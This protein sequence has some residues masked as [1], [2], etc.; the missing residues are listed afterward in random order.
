MTVTAVELLE[1]AGAARIEHPGGTLLDHLK[2]VEAVLDTWGARPAL[3]SAGLCHAFYGT[4]GFPT[5]LLELEHRAALAEAIGAEVEDLV[6]FYASCDRKASYRGLAEQDGLFRDRFTGAEFPPTAQQRRDFA[7]LT[8]ANEL[9]LAAVNPDIRARYG[10][11][12]RT[13]FGR[14]RPLLSAPA[15][16]HCRDVLG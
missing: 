6:Y 7:E 10:S 16:A 1:A 8:A 13:L 11:G 4:D 5:S 15:W 12:L 9:D 2:R 14:W 3:A